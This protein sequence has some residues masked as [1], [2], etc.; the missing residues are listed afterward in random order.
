MGGRKGSREDRHFF[1]SSPLVNLSSN[2]H[3]LSSVSKSR[4]ISG[5]LTLEQRKEQKRAQ[6]N[7]TANSPISAIF[8]K[9]TENY[10]PIRVAI[11]SMHLFLALFNLMRSFIFFLKAFTKP[12]FLY[13]GS[14]RYLCELMFIHRLTKKT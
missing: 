14:D 8:C 10:L 7:L 13:N 2:M 6:R 3:N 9:Y 5:C 11:I 4:L 12:F 1:L